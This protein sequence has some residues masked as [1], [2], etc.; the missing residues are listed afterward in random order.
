[1]VHVLNLV[2]SPQFVLILWI[3]GWTPNPLQ[4]Y[5]FQ[6]S[7]RLLPFLSLIQ[8]GSGTH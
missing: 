8:A 2:N 3:C 1:M 6:S 5:S 7:I 4:D